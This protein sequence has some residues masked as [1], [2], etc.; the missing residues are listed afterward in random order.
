MF[1]TVNQ[2]LTKPEKQSYVTIPTS[3]NNSQNMFIIYV[4]DLSTKHKMLRQGLIFLQK[5][6]IQMVRKRKKIIF[7]LFRFRNS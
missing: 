3:A 6:K 4:I 2:N 1:L 7:Q 5:S